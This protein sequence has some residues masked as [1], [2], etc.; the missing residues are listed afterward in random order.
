M[1]ARHLLILACIVVLAALWSSR[2]SKPHKISPACQGLNPGTASKAMRHRCALEFLQRGCDLGHAKSCASLPEL[3][4]LRPED[5][6][7]GDGMGGGPQI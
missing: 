3:K 1:N 6:P 5:L 4:A 7:D 2:T